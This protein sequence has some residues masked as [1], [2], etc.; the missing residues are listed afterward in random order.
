MITNLKGYLLTDNTIK[1]A[2]IATK[3]ENGITI[4]NINGVSETPLEP[5]FGAK[6]T[7]DIE[8]Y[9]SF[10]ADYRRC[11]FWCEPRFGN[12]LKN[13]PDETQGLIVCHNSEHFSVILPLVSDTYKCV[14]CGTDSGICARLYSRFE[15]LTECH[16]PAFLY[17]EGENPYLLLE[18]CAKLGLQILNNDCK[19]REERHYPE[20]FEYLGW[21]SWDAMEIRVNHADLLKKCEE[22]KEKNIPVK[23][24][25]IDD[26]WEEV[27]DFY[28]AAYQNRNEMFD[29]MHAS[30]LYSF[31]ADPKR[32]PFGLKKCISDINKYGIKVGL[33]HPTTGYWAGIDPEGSLY[34][35][36]KD[37]FI[38]TEKGKIVCDY[39]TENAYQYYKLLHDYFV[40][41]CAE[42][43]K[44]DN[45]SGI[46]LFDF[47][48][49]APIGKVAREHHNAMEKSV[50]EHFNGIMINCMGMASEDMWNR[51]QSPISRCS[52]DFQP[53]DSSWFINH[54]TM[55]AYNDLI[56]GQFYYCDWDMWWTSDGQALKNSILRAISG[57]PIYISDRLNESNSEIISPLVLSDGKILRCDRPAMP[58]RD[59]ITKNPVNSG[60]IFKIQNICNNC[61]VIAAFNI[62]ENN[63][64]VSGTVS[65]SDIEGLV[66][67]CFAVYEHFS[68]K[69]TIMK[70]DD[71]FELLLKDKDDFRLYIVAP[72]NENFAAI[73]RT[74]KFI[75]PKTLKSV[76]NQNVTLLE[77]G[78]YAI[79]ENG[80]LK[81]LNSK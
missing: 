73:G 3:N 65:P 37:L 40:K 75:S 48:R 52:G 71:S 9:D 4:I 11:P 12:D 62:D 56:Q 43:V 32:F 5:D 24:A 29:L 38:K 69:C 80:Q 14:L 17:A 60:I 53:N 35:D 42:F 63:N 47:N 26:M 34:N 7:F 72:Y 18:N 16:A 15:G 6:I 28:D 59:C 2:E 27:H 67:E 54:I 30:K 74:D 13:V 79:V 39:K 41:S 1:N 31:K 78:E 36:Y 33:W 10:M 61:G 23:W 70:K 25:I 20:I 68:K 66:G 22:F 64:S 81:F 76:V 8:N 49:L 45:Q 21:C 19:L 55:C 77:A 51:K 50:S 57:G 46:N 58:T 44:I